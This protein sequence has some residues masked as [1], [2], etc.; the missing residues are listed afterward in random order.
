[1]I[2]LAGELLAVLLT[3]T[4]YHEHLVCGSTLAAG[5][6]QTEYESQSFR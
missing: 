1:M 2:L 3:A 4:A 5:V 6:E